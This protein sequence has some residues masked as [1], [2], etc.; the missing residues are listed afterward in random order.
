MISRPA[1]G[2][3]SDEDQQLVASAY[4]AAEGQ[5]GAH[6]SSSWQVIRGETPIRSTN[7]ITAVTDV[8]ANWTAFQVDA[9]LTAGRVQWMCINPD[10]D[11]QVLAVVAM[12]DTGPARQYTSTD[13]P[14]YVDTRT[15]TLFSRLLYS[16]RII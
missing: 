12:T 10:N 7:Q 5:P 2:V 15:T 14:C 8:Q 4:T 13:V 1:D 3:S 6:E 9:S 11:Q 16:R